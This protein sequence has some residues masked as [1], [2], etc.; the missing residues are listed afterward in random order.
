MTQPQSRIR[1]SFGDLSERALA[2]WLLVP[3]ALL[4]GLVALY[5]VGRL[6]YT[7]LFRRRLTDET[8][9]SPVFVGF[10]NFV[11]AFADERFWTALWNTLLIVLV[12]V[13]GALVV[14]LLLAL[15]ANL[16]FRVKWPV[17][18][19]LLLPWALPLV[20]AGL[21]FRWFFDSQYGVVNDVIVRLG[22]ER[23]LWVTTPELLFWAICIS[24]IWK[25][26]SFVAL[27][28]LAGL[29]V[30]PKELYESAAVDGANRWQSFWRITLP[31]LLPAI[32]VA[33]IFRTITA[34]QTFD[35]PFAMQNGG[36]SFETL[37]MYVRTMSIENLNFGYG[38]ALAVL[39]F[40][41]SF[42]VTLVYLRYVRGADD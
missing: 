17:R 12:T 8:G 37:A 13:P 32:L 19:G 27:I 10:Q 34:F 33:A 9:N 14:G 25:S 4:L 2:F 41:I 1:R 29:Q 22:G 28:L 42:A 21:I 7:S 35:I 15:L 30:I 36:S 38:S 24:I 23:L 18:L 6:L 5:P 40:L 16:P 11:Q 39:M 26:S 3:A 20:F 31:L